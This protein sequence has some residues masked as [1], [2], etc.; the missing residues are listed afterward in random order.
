MDDQLIQNLTLL[1]LYLTSCE[2][3]LSGD[4]KIRRAW[5]GFRFEAL[6]ALDEAGYIN[7]SY[8]AKSLSLTH[9]G[10]ERA[11]ALMSKYLTDVAGEEE[12]DS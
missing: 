7:Q 8:R 2:E 3:E 10:S 4:T 6:N 12:Q 9:V 5:K 1:L 11:R